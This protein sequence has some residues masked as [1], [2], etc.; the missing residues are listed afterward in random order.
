MS[1]SDYSVYADKPIYKKEEDILDR[2]TF[3]EYLGQAVYNFSGNESLVIGLYGKWG[4]GKTSA[5]NMTMHEVKKLSEINKYPVLVM[6]FAPWNYSDKDNL[7]SLFFSNLNRLI[8]K[9]KT[10]DFGSELGQAL[11]DY[12]DVLDVFSSVPVY[13]GLAVLMKLFLKDR[14][15]RLQKKAELNEIRDRLEKALRKIKGKIIVVIDDIDR[16]HNTQIRDIFQLVK[17]VGNLPNITY[18]MVMDKEV[19]VRALSDVQ[20]CDGNAYLEKIVQIPFVIPEFDRVLLKK[21]FTQ[22]IKDILAEYNDDIV[23]EGS[24]YWD[25]IYSN[26]IDPYI[27]TLRDIKRISNTLKF[28]Y[29]IL[30]G[31]IAVEDL[32]AI[33]TIEVL[34]TVLFDW[35]IN[36][37]IKLCG[38]ITYSLITQRRSSD[39]VISEFREEFEKNNIDIERAM[40]FLSTLFPEFAQN[41]NMLQFYRGECEEQH[42]DMRIASKDRFDIYFLMNTKAI[43]VPREVIWSI[44]KD[45]DETEISTALIEINEGGGLEYFT[46][47]MRSMVSRITNERITLLIGVFFKCFGPLCGE[48][49]V[50][51]FAIDSYKQAEYLIFDLLRKLESITVRFQLLINIITIGNIY[52][53]CMASAILMRIEDSFGRINDTQ[54]RADDKIIV[55]EQLNKLENAYVKRL[56]ELNDSYE[57]VSHYRFLDILSVWLYLDESAAKEYIR[58]CSANPKAC[59]KLICRLAGRWSGKT[60]YGWKYK[61]KSLSEYVDLN[62]AEDF[63]V[64]YGKEK[65]T[66]DFS[67]NEILKLV[68]FFYSTKHGDDVGITVEEAR[69]MA[70]ECFDIQI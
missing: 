18:I 66:K 16:L 27:S 44:I 22:N 6:N 49:T 17:Q 11:K 14:G 19:V 69:E 65:L 36:N 64:E 2:A 42:A 31:E 28:K 34:D 57:L 60:G 40:K 37:K 33:T 45:F 70:A 50:D 48:D 15:K 7:I 43:K 21:A 1:V 29:S 59:L 5:V 3:A 41:V 52:E 20:K 47:E 30:R 63:F 35:I 26:C 53:I 62:S 56:Q 67:E 23:L 13:G 12:A 61:L 25:G 10:A 54:E 55:V 58:K 68:S 24:Y 9:D 51:F 46:S 39:D 8:G 4:S 38:N 32:V